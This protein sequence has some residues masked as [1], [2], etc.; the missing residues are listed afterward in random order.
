[1]KT[2]LF[3]RDDDEM[4]YCIVYWHGGNNK[5]EVYPNVIDR[6]TIP[7]NCGIDHVV[8]MLNTLSEHDWE[9]VSHS[10]TKGKWMWVLQK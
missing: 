10:G 5:L 8:K 1:M 2:L 9:L 6:N 4:E 7:A 3:E